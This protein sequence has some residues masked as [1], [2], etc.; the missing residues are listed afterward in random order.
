MCRLVNID[1]FDPYSRAD[2]GSL[3]HPPPSYKQKRMRFHIPNYLI[4]HGYRT[5]TGNSFDISAPFC[6]DVER[7]I[8]PKL[9]Q[10]RF[11]RG[12]HFLPKRRKVIPSRSKPSHASER[13]TKK[14]CLVKIDALVVP[15]ILKKN[16]RER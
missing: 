9:Q 13:S 4:T 10:G 8:T 12:C 15:R 1:I 7:K 6:A 11:L 2:L 14:R 5:N 3:H 16:L